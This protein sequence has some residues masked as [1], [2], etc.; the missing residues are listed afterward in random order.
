MRNEEEFDPYYDGQTINR[1]MLKVNTKRLKQTIIIL[2]I[3]LFVVYPS[4][5][6]LHFLS[7]ETDP[8]EV[9][10]I[11][12]CTF[13]DSSNF[14]CTNPSIEF[15]IL[16]VKR[17]TDFNITTTMLSDAQNFPFEIKLSIYYVFFSER[18]GYHFDVIHEADSIYLP[19]ERDGDYNFEFSIRY[20]DNKNSISYPVSAEITHITTV[21]AKS[22]GE[23][24]WVMHMWIL[25]AFTLFGSHF[26]MKYQLE[27]RHFQKA[28]EGE[29]PSEY[30]KFARDMQTES[31]R[32]ALHGSKRRKF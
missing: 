20:I 17:G 13:W 14:D 12:E 5:T 27:R 9:E 7:Y 25:M 15:Q 16:G 4:F 31:F 21:E 3:L 6:V 11:N 28:L 10:R 24:T 22:Y 23:A 1:H 29:D 32:P 18:E 19:I 30:A 2:S 8:V 26:V